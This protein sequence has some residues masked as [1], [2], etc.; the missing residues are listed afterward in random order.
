[1]KNNCKDKAV[2][3]YSTLK[4]W[5]DANRL[6]TK[7]GGKLTDGIGVDILRKQILDEEARGNWKGAAELAVQAQLYKEAI[8]I[9]GKRGY[10]D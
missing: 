9:Y 6:V 1:M 10:L 5:A 7:G 3:M 8:E 2:Q 4:L